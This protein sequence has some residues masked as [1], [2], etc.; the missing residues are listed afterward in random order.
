MEMVVNNLKTAG[1]V[2]VV[3][4]GN[5]GSGCS[6]VST[7]AAIFESSF[8]IGATRDND[9]IANFS[10]RGPVLVDGS[11][12]MKPDVSAPG[13]NV[14]SSIPGGGYA[15]FSGTSMAGPHV[16]GA[17]AL[18]ISARPDLAGEVD[19][20]E[21]LLKNTARIIAAADTCGG[22]PGTETPNN[23]YGWGRIDVFEAVKLAL[24]QLSTS[25]PST[26]L[27]AS[28]L[29]N[30]FNDLLQITWPGMDGIGTFQ[31]YDLSGRM[32]FEQQ[33]TLQDA[34]PVTLSMPTIHPGFYSYRIIAGNQLS[35]GK[36]LRS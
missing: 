21:D 23:T 17:V 30:P 9:T 27:A 11:G 36:L 35:S 32:V 31:L 28:V 3:S 24:K 19:V 20:I 2:V 7:P 10:S 34:V 26:T 25:T 4:A 33:L 5:S 15:N 6:S 18:I 1:V 12:R 14:R 22:V 16:A 13:V 29:P 8:T